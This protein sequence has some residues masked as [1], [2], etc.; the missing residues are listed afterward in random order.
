M[1]EIIWTVVQALIAMIAVPTVKAVFKENATPK[2]PNML[3]VEVIGHQWWWEFRYPEYDLTRHGRR[4]VHVPVRAHRG[5]SGRLSVIHSWLPEFAGKR[6]VF[7]NREI[8]WFTAEEPGE[9]RASAEFCGSSTRQ[10]ALR[11]EA[12]EQGGVPTSVDHMKTLGAQPAAAGGRGPVHGLG[13]HV[14]GGRHRAASSRP[15]IYAAQARS[16][17]SP[18]E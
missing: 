1:V 15:G 2:G 17:S 13:P 4:V 10:M 18:R 11:V 16:C 14:D 8:Q 7:P 3:T 6:D 5:S 9:Y 12:Q